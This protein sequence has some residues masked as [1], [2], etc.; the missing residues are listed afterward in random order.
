M[1]RCLHVAMQMAPGGNGNDAAVVDALA[2]GPSGAVRRVGMQKQLSTPFTQAI[3]NP[4]GQP[5]T[6]LLFFL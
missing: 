4:L 2:S 3:S 6:Q 5:D 1:R